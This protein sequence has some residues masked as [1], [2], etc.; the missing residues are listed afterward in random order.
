M[1]WERLELSYLLI[2][3]LNV[4]DYRMSF[5]K[6]LKD[7]FWEHGLH[8]KLHELS[9]HVEFSNIYLNVN[10]FKFDQS[11]SKISWLSKQVNCT[12]PKF[13]LKSNF[14]DKLRFLGLMA[15]LY[16]FWSW[17]MYPKFLIWP[18]DILLLVCEYS[19]IY[20]ATFSFTIS[21]TYT[22]MATSYICWYYCYL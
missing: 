2:Y 6:S 12:N 17:M 1:T 20:S 14:P 18:K 13:E 16:F 22:Y 7:C 8:F 5:N 9:C 19:N 11:K 3:L 10:Y 4:L 21:V 15:S